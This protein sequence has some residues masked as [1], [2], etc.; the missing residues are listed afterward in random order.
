MS[1]QLSIKFIAAL[2]AQSS[3]ISEADN[4]IARVVKTLLGGALQMIDSAAEERG[5]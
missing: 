5:K 4:Q 3:D 2:E 1:G